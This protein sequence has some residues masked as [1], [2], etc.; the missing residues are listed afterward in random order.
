MKKQTLTPIEACTLLDGR[1]PLKHRKNAATGKKGTQLYFAVIDHCKDQLFGKI[2]IQDTK[3]V[4]IPRTLVLAAH[5]GSQQIQYPKKYKDVEFVVRD[6][7]H[8]FK[9]KGYDG[10]SYHL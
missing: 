4:A 6:F 5:K 10:R 8:T 7:M 3:G 2:E 1:L 9:I